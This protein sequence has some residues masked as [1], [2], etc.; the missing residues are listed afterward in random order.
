MNTKFK[1]FIKIFIYALILLTILLLLSISYYSYNID[2]LAYVLCLGL[3]LNDNNSLELTF[4]FAIPSKIAGSSKESSDSGDSE[5]VSIASIECNNINTGFNLMNSQLTKK[6]NMSH[7]KTIIFSE[8]VAKSGLNNY[9][10]TLLNDVEVQPDA[11]IFISKNKASYIINNTKPLVEKD[12]ANYYKTFSI[13]SYYTGYTKEITLKEFFSNIIDTTIEPT[14]ILTSVSNQDTTNVS[15]NIISPNEYIAGNTPINSKPH[16]ENIGLAVF[17]ND[18]LVGE[19]NSIDTICNLILQKKLTSCIVTIPS[20]FTDSDTIDLRIFQEKSPNI[21]VQMINGSPFIKVILQ[22]DA[23]ITSMN[24]VSNYLN[25]ENLNIVSNYANKYL[26]KQI[27]N[28]LYKTAKEFKSD[29]N[30]FGKYE[31]RKSLFLNEWLS[32]KWLDNYENSFFDVN[33]DVNV[34]SSYMILDS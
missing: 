11:N 20:P 30:N 17:S 28:Y 4:Q 7:C 19:L 13:S 5:G 10:Y 15:S 16:I 14:A 27:S 18:T 2:D 26:E 9:I 33:I 29:V 23:R 31:I 12:P 25:Q 34:L 21:D 8:N 1:N 22:L 32:K 24:K 6:L 3:D